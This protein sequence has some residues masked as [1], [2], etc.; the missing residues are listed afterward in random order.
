MSYEPNYE[1]SPVVAGPPGGK[2][3]AHGIHS[4]AARAGH[5]LAPQLLSSG[6]NVFEELGPGFTL[7]AFGADS[8]RFRRGGARGRGVPLKIVRDTYADG[9]KQYGARLILVRPDQY[10]VWA[11]DTPPEDARQLLNKVTG[12]NPC[13]RAA[14]VFLLCGALA[15][16]VFAADKHYGP[17][18]TD[19][20]IKIGQT[21]SYSG[22]VSAYGVIGRTETAYFKALNEAGGVNGRKIVFLS[23]DDGY[24][25]PKALEQTRRLVEQDQVLAIMGTLGTPTNLATRKYLNDGMCRNSS[26]PPAPPRSR[27][28]RISR[29]LFRSILPT[30][31][32][33]A[34]MRNIS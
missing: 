19:T 14:I 21:M 20:E 29:G 4:F 27:T 33:A 18:V 23:V 31:R 34:L 17:G 11:G 8:R 26:S 9:R 28:R 10:V 25:P 2:C 32:K 5:H 6:R 7:L 12:R 3:S 22:P 16:P 15:A 30:R 13:R 1:G 24:S